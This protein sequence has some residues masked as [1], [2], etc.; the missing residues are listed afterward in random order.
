MSW[1]EFISI[2]NGTRIFNHGADECVAVANLYHEEVLGGSFIGVTAAHQWWTLQWA[3]IDRLYT[4]SL[5]P[6]AGAIFVGQGG[7]YD[8]TSGHIGGVVANVDPAGEWFDTVEQNAGS[9]AARYFWRYRRANDNSI[10]GFLVPKNNPATQPLAP[11]QRQAGDLPVNRRAAPTS[12]SENLGDPIPAH[13]IGNFNGWV[14]GENVQGIDVWFRGISGAWFWAGG[15]TSQATDG[16]EDLNPPAPPA[17][18][19]NQRQVGAGGANLRAEPS[20]GAVIVGNLAANAIV[21]V[22]AWGLGQGIEGVAM[23]YK[24][25][26]AYS[27]AGGFT[28]I[29]DHDL[30]EFEEQSDID[31]SLPLDPTGPGEDRGHPG[32]VLASIDRWS[33]E[34]PDWGAS[35]DR[36]LPASVNLAIPDKIV[37]RTVRPDRGFYV[38]REGRPNHIVIHHGVSL[39]LQGLIDS[40]MGYNN[41]SASAVIGPSEIVYMVD[42]RDTP[43]TN[44]RWRSNQ[45]SVTA[46]LLNDG[47]LSG[48]PSPETHEAAAWWAAGEA[49]R[50][51][52]KLPLARLETVFGHREVSKSA[53][54]CP[55]EVNVDWITRRANEIIEAQLATTPVPE[56]DFDDLT[57]AIGGLTKVLQAILDFLKNLFGGRSA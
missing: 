51:G 8:R 57:A 55:G 42:S 39:R 45:Y 15:F 21:T 20:T 56:P 38:G 33:E 10:W 37:Q 50:W 12:Q 26:D 40:L 34:A 19:P 9:G 16:L 31:P 49:L 2:P 7:I 1:A 25:G 29:G 43:A 4:K 35:W 52:M 24:I 14:R 30:P 13:D 36:P 54:S 6:V 47:T 46:E 41:N 48:K 23:W 17:V 22:D 27:W 28:E 11:Q 3:E 5:S 53:T 44:T 18:L 32:I